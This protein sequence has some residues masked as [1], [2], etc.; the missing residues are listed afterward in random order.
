ME[1]EEQPVNPTEEEIT[2][3]A[4]AEGEQVASE[5]PAEEAQPEAPAAE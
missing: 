5:A 2:P 4:P 1:N 3:A